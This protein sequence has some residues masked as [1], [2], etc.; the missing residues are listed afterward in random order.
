MKLKPDLALL[1]WE[2]GFNTK[3]KGA[4]KCIALTGDYNGYC[5][6]LYIERVF[7]GYKSSIS[8]GYQGHHISNTDFKRSSLM[9][10]ISRFTDAI[11]I[12]QA[13]FVLNPDYRYPG[14]EDED[15][16]NPF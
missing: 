8:I 6:T 9:K 5:M 2:L 15:D 10:V 13:K 7:L 1:L 16:W 11:E 12:E 3:G 14:H 4:F